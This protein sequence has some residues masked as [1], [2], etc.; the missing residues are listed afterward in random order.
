MKQ[1]TTIGVGVIVQRPDAKIL[2][3]YRHKKG[4]EPSWC[5]PGGHVEPEESFEEA[6]LRE[7]EEE[8]GLKLSNATI[9][10]FVQ[11]IGGGASN[12]TG[13]A[14]S[15]LDSPQEADT[16]EPEVFKY[17]KW[18][19]LDEI[20]HPLFPATHAALSAWQG[21]ALDHRWKNYRVEN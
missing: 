9:T 19:S 1:K 12:L 3:G 17:W 16:R 18:F 7:T 5:F 10:N 14:Y 2:L 6:A 15:E 13:V 20:P 4:E 8:T 21:Y 11:N